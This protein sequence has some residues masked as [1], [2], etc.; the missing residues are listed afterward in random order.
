MHRVMARGC[1]CVH[2]TRGVAGLLGGGVE[3]PR[4]IS[5]ATATA[6]KA[7]EHHDPEEHEA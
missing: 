3:G 5:A 4:L 7:D 1:F 6:E 2:S